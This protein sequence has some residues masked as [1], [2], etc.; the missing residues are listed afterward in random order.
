[1]TMLTRWNPLKSLPRIDNGEFDDLFRSLALR[2]M[3]RDVEMTPEIRVDVTENDGAYDISADLPGVRKEDIDVTVDGNQV[4]IV[5]ETR[6]ESEKKD[7]G[8]EVRSERYY[9][10]VFRSFSLP[11]D[12]DDTKAEARYENGVLTLRLPKKPNGQQRRI[13][14]S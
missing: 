6:R 8:R 7:G 2:P 14:V 10:Q 1:M 13:A 9:G 11:V 12:V 5:A 4:S 3:F